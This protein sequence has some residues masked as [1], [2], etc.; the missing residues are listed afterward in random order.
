MKNFS[1]SMWKVFCQECA[2]SLRLIYLSV[3]FSG[4]W[5]CTFCRDLSKPEVEY[6][7]DKPTHNP[8][9]RKLEDTVGLAPIDRR[10][11]MSS[12]VSFTENCTHLKKKGRERAKW[13]NNCFNGLWDLGSLHVNMLSNTFW[14]S[15]K[16]WL[17]HAVN[18]DC[19]LGITKLCL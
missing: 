13:R 17:F 16:W 19:I 12:V 4:E 5:I 9:K 15:E 10:V 11:R 3:L 1:R 6:D 2:S 8:E 18:G 14:K 7:C